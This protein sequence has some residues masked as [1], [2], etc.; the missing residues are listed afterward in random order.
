M[1][2]LCAKGTKNCHF[3]AEIVKS[4]LNWTQLKSSCEETGRTRNY[5]GG[6]QNALMPPAALPLQ[7]K[8]PRR[9]KSHKNP[10][11]AGL[12]NYVRIIT[13]INGKLLSMELNITIK[14]NIK[15]MQQLNDWNDQFI[16][17]EFPI[18]NSV[19]TLYLSTLLH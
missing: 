10:H 19:F 17:Y 9:K 1:K 11:E 12:K 18:K 2:I 5:G 4:V 6:G 8:K 15:C 7:T 3:N 13:I 16:L 14:L